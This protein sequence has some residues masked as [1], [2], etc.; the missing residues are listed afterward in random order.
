[1]VKEI[2]EAEKNNTLGSPERNSR[3]YTWRRVFKRRT[4]PG[5]DIGYNIYQDR[6]RMAVSGSGNGYI[7]KENNRL[8]SG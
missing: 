5:M 7:L 4:E 2:Q 6:G 8:G 3:E 1:M